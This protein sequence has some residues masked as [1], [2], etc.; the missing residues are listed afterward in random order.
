MVVIGSGV[1]A[2]FGAAT[3]GGA[4]IV[5]VEVTVEVVP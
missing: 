1:L 3:N 5:W 4:Y 2:A